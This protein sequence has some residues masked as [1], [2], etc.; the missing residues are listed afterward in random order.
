MSDCCKIDTR[1]PAEKRH[2]F[3]ATD[4]SVIVKTLYKDFSLP[5]ATVADYCLRDIQEPQTIVDAYIYGYLAARGL[6]FGLTMDDVFEWA[7][8]GF[9][10]V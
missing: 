3:I 5:P 8:T 4:V 9:L 1:T 2:D 6:T 10:S 7:C